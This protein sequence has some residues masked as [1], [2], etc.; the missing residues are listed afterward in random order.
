MTF[1]Q[2]YAH[3]ALGYTFMLTCFTIQV[4]MQPLR[5]YPPLEPLLPSVLPPGT[6]PDRR[7]RPQM[8]ILVNGFF[9]KAHSVES[10][11]DIHIDV[12]HLIRGL[13]TA[14]RAPTTPPEPPL[15]LVSRR[16]GVAGDDRAR[17]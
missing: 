2:R 10:P 13:F 4:I 7:R 6:A 8:A 9:D 11:H 5:S 1:L 16:L 14:V 17:S 15:R 12:T 3:S